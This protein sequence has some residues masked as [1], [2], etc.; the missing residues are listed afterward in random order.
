M[1]CLSKTLLFEVREVPFSSLFRYV[2]HTT[3]CFT[4]FVCVLYFCPKKYQNG[5]PNGGGESPENLSVDK[6]SGIVTWLP[7]Q[8][9]VGKHDIKVKIEAI[10]VFPVP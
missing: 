9:Q 3:F 1:F 2:F 4:L 6:T 7:T 5:Y 8:E 10:V